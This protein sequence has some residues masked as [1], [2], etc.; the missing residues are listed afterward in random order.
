MAENKYRAAEIEHTWQ[1]RWAAD[2]LY[3]ATVDHTKPAYYALTMYPYPSGDLHMGHWYA[4]VPSDARA[5]WMRMRGYNVLFPIGFDSFGLPAENAAIRRGIHPKTWTYDNIARMR[6][7]LRS[8]GA[9][10]DW[11]REV[12]TSDPGYYKWTQW[13][14]RKLYDMG[15]A[16]KKLAPVDFCPMCNTTLA[17]EQVWGDDRHCERCDTP[18]IKKDLE[19]WFFKI[20]AYAEELLD[21]SQ[22]EW[23]ERVKS[24]QTN[25]IGR[26]TGATVVFKTTQGA[27]DIPIFTTRPDTL[28][29]ATFLVLAPEHPLVATLTPTARRHEVEA[30]VAR[31]TRATEVERLALD[32]DKT[33][34]F[35]GAY[36][37]NP[38]NQERIPIWIA[39]YVLMSYGTG[40]IMAVPAHDER[41]FA[42]AQ[43]YQLP[44]RTVIAPPG[45]NPDQSLEAAYTST[46][47]G[48][49]VNSGLFNGTPVQEAIPRVIAWL[50]AQGVGKGAVT[51]R[52]HDWL[53]SRQRY[54]GAP[55]PMITC[56]ACGIV[57]VPYGELPVLLPDDVQFMPTGE[58]PLLHHATFRHVPCPHCGTAAVRETD[59][60]DTFMCSSWYQYAYMNPTWKATEPLQADDVPYDP[61]EGAYWLPVD[62]YTGG[63]EHAT[64]HLLYTRFFT[65]AMRDMGLV[66]FDE[67]MLRLYNQGIILGEDRDKMSKS[68]GNVIAPDDLVQQYGADTVRGY[69]MFGFRWD[70][71]GPW[72]STGILGLQRFLER[73]WELVTVLPIAL[74]TPTEVQVR[75][76]QR[77]QHQTIRKVTQDMERF[78][79]NTMVAALM[80]YSNVLGQSKVTPVVTHAVWQEAIRTLV[81]LLAPAFPHLA[82]ELWQ[83]IGGAYSVHQQ[84]WPTW[85]HE[86][87][88]EELLTIVVQVNGKLREKFQ[89]SADISEADAKVQALACEGVQRHL[90][91]KQPLKVVYVPGRLVNI[92]VP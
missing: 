90:H 28:W 69:L 45:H 1:Q 41:D 92:V 19:Q 8:M 39:D 60:M 3:H 64:M 62:Q 4:M 81:L 44:I 22:L 21:Y 12:I 6:Q 20:T 14:F 40:A 85:D 63:V 37:I 17:R 43:K 30:Y 77:K 73:V 66:D 83:T 82:E 13:F 53:I 75:A 7:Q 25:W 31:A 84:A 54:W 88:A 2:Q 65:K 87:A 80:E 55:I 56:P 24:M 36:A 86:L 10:F 72:S 79:F 71:G 47:A 23:P 18:V 46:E 33:G 91:G 5:R 58:S 49:M 15:L 74:G 76:L 42:F 68:R 59:T 48:V 32:K 9:M 50:E 51:Y 16:Y 78:A 70:Q 26:S 67:P 27:H 52:L 34:V 11:E 38:V 57:P 35:I 89:A 29:G 61:Q